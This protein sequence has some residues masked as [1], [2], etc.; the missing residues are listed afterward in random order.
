MCL[1]HKKRDIMKHYLLYISFAILLI[2]SSCRN[3]GNKEILIKNLYGSY[4]NIKTDSIEEIS[5]DNLMR[6]KSICNEQFNVIVYS[7][8]TK[9]SSCEVQSLYEWDNF[10]DE[11]K[12]DKGIGL[13]LV[14]IFSPTK[15]GYLNLKNSIKNAKPS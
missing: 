5:I 9:C 10:V 13:G 7:D 6:D 4:I 2:F 15:E 11:L 12:R 8:S 14:Y 1:P 3:S